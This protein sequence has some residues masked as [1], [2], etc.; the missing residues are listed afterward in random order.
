LILTS[1]GSDVA[2]PWLERNREL[3]RLL[4][5]GDSPSFDQSL[6]QYMADSDAK[7]VARL[8]AP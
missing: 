4:I 1:L 2:G 5:A 3:L 7:V 8:A 6:R